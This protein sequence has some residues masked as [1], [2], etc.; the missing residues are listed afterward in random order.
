MPQ[1]MP[2]KTC[3]G[4]VDTD[5]NTIQKQHVKVNVEFHP[6]ESLDH[7]NGAGLCGGSC[8]AGFPSQ[9]CGNGAADDAQHFAHDFGLSRSE[10]CSR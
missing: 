3:T 6:P 7:S 4:F 1:V 9:V 10:P 5:V 8:K 2:A